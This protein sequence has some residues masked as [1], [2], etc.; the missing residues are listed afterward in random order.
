MPFT[1][2][3]VAFKDALE[4]GLIAGGAL[5]VVEG[6]T[7]VFNQKF[8]TES[9]LQIYNELRNISNLLLTPHIGFFTDHAVKNM[10]VE[11]LNDTLAF[12]ENRPTEHEIKL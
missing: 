12:L 3:T 5:D 9:P 4:S 8:D 6:E 2:D 1:V 10:V 7:K 11:S